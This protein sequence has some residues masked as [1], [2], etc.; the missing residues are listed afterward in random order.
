MSFI[1]RLK[2][3]K[4]LFL[5]KLDSTLLRL[6]S[7]SLKLDDLSSTQQEFLSLQQQF[8]LLQQQF[9]T[10]LQHL[11]TLTSQ[12]QFELLRHEMT[13]NKS[14]KFAEQDQARLRLFKSLG[15]SPECIYDIGASNGFWSR[16][17]STVFPNARYHLFE[18]LAEVVPSYKELLDINLNSKM[19]ATLHPIA[20]GEKCGIASL[21]MN[22]SYFDSSFLLEKKTDEFP[23]SIDVEM[24]T[25]DAA[26]QK[27]SLPQPQLL[28][29]DTQGYELS[30]LKGA[31]ETLKQVDII[32]LEAWI[33]RGYGQNTPLLFELAEWLARRN[34]FLLDVADGYRNDT[35]LLTTLDCFFVRQ[36]GCVV[37][38]H[39][40][41]RVKLS[42][43][44]QIVPP[45][46]ATAEITHTANQPPFPVPVDELLG[47]L[48]SSTIA[49]LTVNPFPKPLCFFHIPKTAGTSLRYWLADF[50]AAADVT[51][52]DIVE[53]LKTVLPDDLINYRFYAA[54]LGLALYQLLP[55]SPDT[56]TWLRDPVAREISQYTYV[57]QIKDYLIAQSPSQQFL[58]YVNAVCDLSISDLC[59]SDVYLSQ[60]H[61]S[62]SR[63]LASITRK[64]PEAST[65][66]L[67]LQ[68]PWV[69][70]PR[71]SCNENILESA[72]QNLLNLLHFGMCDW[73]QPSVDLLCYRAGLPPKAFDYYINRTKRDTDQFS[74][75]DR[76]ILRE[77]NRYD[78]ALYEFA[79]QEFKNRILTLWQDCV[80]SGAIATHVFSDPDLYPQLVTSNIAS[81]DWLLAHWEHP[82]M[83]AVLTQFLKINFQQQHHQDEQQEQIRLHFSDAA[84]LTGWYAREYYQPLETWLRWAGPTTESSVYLPLKAGSDYRI[85]FKVLF[86]MSYD[87]L[88]S[89]R[90]QVR[91]EEVPLQWTSVTDASGA[92]QYLVTGV[93]PARLLLESEVYTELV[94]KTSQVVRMELPDKSLTDAYYVSFATDGFLV[95]VEPAK[96]I[97]KY[98]DAIPL[99]I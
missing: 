70:V 67:I 99:Q 6:D 72:K 47:K 1:Q 43:V 86:C 29:L 65:D 18:P 20:L 16:V 26:V 54:H 28:K 24:L 71:G 97:R 23:S 98:G 12:Q 81:A 32:L 48:E 84:F 2:A 56:I 90:L 64:S 15:F 78:Q 58:T 77:T 17:V 14:K 87:I 69:H 5:S 85:S 46:D 39:A 13:E 49:P 50:F 74:E 22:S 7:T 75:A 21:F 60:Y 52:I 11:E 10:N 45:A 88:Q 63:M 19:N 8:L 91:G 59:Q 61:N 83:R 80:A 25:L 51:S 34:F 57:R 95:E 35:G 93:I 66:T 44:V 73:M 3:I 30:I 94:L 42:P 4:D 76:A 62:Q 37:G 31:E 40:N 53:D 41:R 92:I 38:L 55:E 68:C 36:P 82:D 27:F 33:I 9:Q 89:M 79:Q 96:S